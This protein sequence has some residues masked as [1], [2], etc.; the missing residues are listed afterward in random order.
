MAFLL[1]D[2]STPVVWRGPIKLGA[3]QQFIG[4]VDWGNL[5]SWSLISH[6]EQAMN[7]SL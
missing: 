1:E 2:E 3:I 6:Q 5:I 4:D 7:H